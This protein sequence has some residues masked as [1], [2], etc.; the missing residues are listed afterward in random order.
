MR[1]VMWLRAG[2]EN[3]AAVSVWNEVLLLKL[4][5]QAPCE[6][7]L[8]EHMEQSLCVTPTEL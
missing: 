3:E 4:S 8:R 2:W 6:Q 7:H 5:V 1:A